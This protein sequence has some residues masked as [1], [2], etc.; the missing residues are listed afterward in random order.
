MIGTHQDPVEIAE[1]WLRENRAIAL[2]TVIETSGSALRDCGSHMVVRDDG[3]FVGS[4]SGGCVEATIL[5]AAHAAIQDGKLRQLE[6]GVQD[7]QGW[8][9][10]LACGGR[11]RVLVE[12]L[13]GPQAHTSLGKLNAC[14]R[15]NRA[16]VR[17]VEVV[18]G[19]SFLLESVDD[20]SSLANAATEVARLDQSKSLWI[21]QREWFFRV[22]NPPLDLVVVGAVHI[23]QPLCR[24]ASLF[25][26]RVRVIDPRAVFA[27][28]ERFPDVILV[29]AFPDEALQ[30]L[31]AR[32]AVVVLSHDPKIDDPALVAA[33]RS[34]AFYI[35]AL[36]SKRTQAARL[37]RL[38]ALGIPDSALT[39]IH[40]PIGLAIGAKTPQEIAISILAEITQTRRKPS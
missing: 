23:A 24:M 36:G 10:G 12:P 25:D 22:Y 9:V 27:T 29:R 40:G 21:E 19:A 4:V 7:E 20:N 28:S 38:K 33:L 16:I 2:V 6:F 5:D 26:F 8:N 34:L 3:Y 13:C 31:T 18:T 15:D 14:R 11:I 30:D 17:A 35:G 1:Q 32:S 39:R 37:A